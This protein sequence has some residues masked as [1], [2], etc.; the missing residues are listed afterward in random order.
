MSGIEEA[1]AIGDEDS[2]EKHSLRDAGDEVLN[3]LLPGERRHGT[4]E[5]VFGFFVAEEASFPGI[6]GFLVS[7]KVGA[8]AAS[9][10]WVLAGR[11]VGIERCR[12]CED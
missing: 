10:G 5:G 9:Y 8:G 2:A 4:A 11:R 1:R 6:Y 12:W 3:I 7:L